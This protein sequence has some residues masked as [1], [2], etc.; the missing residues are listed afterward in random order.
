ML[1]SSKKQALQ[2]KASSGQ[3]KHPP[4]WVSDIECYSPTPPKSDLTPVFICKS[5]TDATKFE[6]RSA[7][8]VQDPEVLLGGFPSSFLGLVPQLLIFASCGP[9]SYQHW[10]KG[11]LGEGGLLKKKTSPTFL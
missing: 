10:E 6:R 2:I 11:S 5:C 4:F 8:R 3:R 9:L 1:G 7:G